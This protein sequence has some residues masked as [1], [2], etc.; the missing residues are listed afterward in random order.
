M[1][2]VSAFSC[3]KSYFFDDLCTTVDKHD[4]S[5]IFGPLIER[6]IGPIVIFALVFAIGRVAR[7]VVDR[8]VPFVPTATRRFAPWCATWGARSSISSQCSAAWSRR[9]YLWHSC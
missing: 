3:D 8:A 5:G 9:E 2:A 6:L 1:L 4:P 7:R